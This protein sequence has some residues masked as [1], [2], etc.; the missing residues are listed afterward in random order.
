MKKHRAARRTYDD[1]GER[2]KV[3]VANVRG[4]VRFARIKPLL[5]AVVAAGAA[6]PRG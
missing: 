1:D 6:V 4:D 5:V 2:K 3:V